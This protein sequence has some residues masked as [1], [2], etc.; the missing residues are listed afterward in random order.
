MFK[1]F[2]GLSLCFIFMGCGADGF[3]LK[4]KFD[5]VEG[6]KKNDRVVFEKN[7]IGLVDEL[8]Y[9]QD[10]FFTVQVVIK[11]E[12]EKLLTEHSRFF[13]DTDPQDETRKVVE[14]ILTAKKGKPLKEGTLVEGNSRHSA[15]LDKMLKTLDQGFDEFESQF[16]EFSEQLKALPESK[17]YQD[18][19]EEL[20][21]FSQKMKDAGEKAREKWKN[22]L[23]PRLKQQLE[24][25]REKLLN[26]PKKEAPEGP[27]AI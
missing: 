25:L 9:M 14:M 22:E 12:F 5:H 26:P 7:Q 11:E 4:I 17:A 23:A 24:E 21:R 8:Q 19:K 2:I 16:K 15:H 6:L 13:I 18:L 3:D 1:I 27:V 20:E 10:G